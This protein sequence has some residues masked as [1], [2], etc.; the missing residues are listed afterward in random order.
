MPSN[1]VVGGRH[2]EQT[3]PAKPDNR[4]DSNCSFSSGGDIQDAASYGWDQ[5]LPKGRLPCAYSVH[6]P[7][8]GHSCFSGTSLKSVKVA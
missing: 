8:S 3:Q 2:Y 1:D 6:G 5:L 7:G 4:V